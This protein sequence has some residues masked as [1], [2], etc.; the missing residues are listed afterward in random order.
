[1]TQDTD[2][3]TPRPT[4]KERHCWFCGAS[5]GV[6][7]NRHYCSGDTCGRAE[8]EREARHSAQVERYEAR[9]RL[10]RDMGWD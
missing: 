8:C 2:K 9:D 7:E 1:M 5:M 10:D 3:S 6:I 4:A